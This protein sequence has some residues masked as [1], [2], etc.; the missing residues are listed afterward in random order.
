MIYP[1]EFER[2][3]Q[4]YKDKSDAEHYDF[5]EA[6]INADALMCNVLEQLGYHAGIKIFYEMGKWYS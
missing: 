3:M 5:E 1:A 6:H 2:K 4:E